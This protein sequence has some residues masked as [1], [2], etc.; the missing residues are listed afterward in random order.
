MLHAGQ[1][2]R[3]IVN[4]AERAAVL[5]HLSFS[6]SDMAKECTNMRHLFDINLNI[7]S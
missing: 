7:F 6:S 4:D 5:A 1:S 2:R 3:I